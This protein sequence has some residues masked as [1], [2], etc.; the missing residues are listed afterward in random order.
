MVKWKDNGRFDIESHLNKPPKVLLKAIELLQSDHDFGEGE[1]KQYID[2][3]VKKSAKLLALKGYRFPDRH[4]DQ[5]FKANY[6][7]VSG[8]D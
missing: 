2:E 5:L 8:E 4:K 1:M 7:H 3:V 6:H